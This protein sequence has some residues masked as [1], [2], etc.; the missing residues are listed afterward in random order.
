M[1]L[2]LSSLAW[3]PEL[4]APVA[5]LL[6]AH[7]MDAIDLTPS[8]YFPNPAQ[9]TEQQIHAIRQQWADRGIEI[10][11]MQALLHG[12]RGLALY[13]DEAARDAML[14][15]LRQ[16]CRLGRELGALRLTFGCMHTRQRQGRPAEQCEAIAQ[17]FFHRLGD[18]AAQNNVTLCIEPVTGSAY[19]LNSHTQ[20]AAF[21]ARLNHPAVK[22]QLDSSA[23]TRAREPAEKILAAHAP[24]IG[25]VHASESGLKPIGDA[26][27]A[28]PV[29]H[30]ALATSLARHLPALPVT[31]EM[32][33]TT[34]E[35]P[36]TPSPA[37]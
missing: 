32:L 10:I 14:T 25:H 19:Y 29:N 21:L 18:C 26:T 37:P 6:L 5:D 31:L 24:I 16:R 9:A 22:L 13:G 27:E 7:R 1:R 28:P 8:H 15:H 12:T 3:P 17:D 2:S 36:C 23:L 11:G 30:A 34:A 33:A 4:D 35:P 20:T